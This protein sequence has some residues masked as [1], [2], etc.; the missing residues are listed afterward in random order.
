MNNQNKY[1][2][3]VSK[4]C[5]HLQTSK[6]TLFSESRKGNLPMG[7]HCIAYILKNT[8]NDLTLMEIGAMINRYDHATV[9]HCLKRFD[10]LLFTNDFEAKQLYSFVV[11]ENK[12]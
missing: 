10:D 5:E 8:D 9:I 4:V 12:N 7:R 3:I 1:D 2:E 11:T 6:K